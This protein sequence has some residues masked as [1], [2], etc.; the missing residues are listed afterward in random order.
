MTMFRIL[1]AVVFVASLSAQPVTSPYQY[2]AETG[3]SYDYYGHQPAST[4]GFGLRV[5]NT[6]AFSVT[7]V[8][9]LFGNGAGSLT[10]ATLRTGV[11]YHFVESAQWL[12]GGMGAAGV[13]VQTSASQA[14][15]GNF[16][17]GVILGYNIGNFITRK[18]T[19]FWLIG[20]YRLNAVT[21]TQVRPTYTI[22]LRK[23]FP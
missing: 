3:L 20:E 16:Q 15:L 18:K 12:F 17:G 8:D 9:T 5:A 4:T 22:S 7:D 11:E 19:G 6:N 1:A 21:S 13:S 23:T 10:S 14:I 2:F